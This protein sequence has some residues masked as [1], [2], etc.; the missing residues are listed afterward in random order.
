MSTPLVTV[1]CLC[2]NQG[3]YVLAAIQSVMSQSYQNVQLIIIDDASTDGSVSVIED[4]LN[5]HPEIPFIKQAENTGNCK[6]FNQALKFAKGEYIIDLAADDVLLPERIQQGVSTFASNDSEYGVNFSDAAYINEKSEVI[7]Q[8]Y[9]RDT[10]GQLISEVPQGDVFKDVVQSYFI[11]SP[12]TMIKKSLF[13]ELGGYDESLVYE[14]F[15]LWVRA[16]RNWKFC[17]TDHILV[18]KRVLPNSHGQQQYK[19]GNLQMLSTYR[20]CVKA[21]QLCKNRSEYKALRKRI[22][23]ELKHAIWLLKL[24]LSFKYFSLWI[25][26]MR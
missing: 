21:L 13:D 20:V 17:Y 10:S 12:T 26:S 24:S 6:A 15:D 14:D 19:R 8:H 11:C 25:K 2:F 7:K 1:I 9:D 18:H 3:D 16:S 23:Y 4:F 5:T 22:Q